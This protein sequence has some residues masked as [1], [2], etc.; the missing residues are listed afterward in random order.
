MGTL[1]TFFLIERK[2]MKLCCIFLS[3]KG[4][5]FIRNFATKKRNENFSHL[6]LKHGFHKFRRIAKTYGKISRKMSN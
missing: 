5:I 2:K 6:N 4:Q 1:N 3:I